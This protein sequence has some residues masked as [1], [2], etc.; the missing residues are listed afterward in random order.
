MRWCLVQEDPPRSFG[1]REGVRW[2]RNGRP[3]FE[4]MTELDG[5]G[6]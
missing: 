6:G 4:E 3:R 2:V 1:E 5:V